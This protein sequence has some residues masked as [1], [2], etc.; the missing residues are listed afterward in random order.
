MLIYKPSTALLQAMIP[1]AQGKE[2]GQCHPSWF[3][4]LRVA[5]PQAQGR[6]LLL[7]FLGERALLT[8]KESER[9]QLQ[10]YLPWPPF[11]EPQPRHFGISRNF[12]HQRAL[13]DKTTSLQVQSKAEILCFTGKT[14]TQLLPSLSCS[15]ICSLSPGAKWKIQQEAELS[16]GKES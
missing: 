16:A 9:L 7:E 6:S 13:S 4:G 1:Q 8:P 15:G 5:A 14:D 12:V 10:L 11:P 3:D 2:K